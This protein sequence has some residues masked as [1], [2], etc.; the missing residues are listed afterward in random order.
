M[1]ENLPTL[2]LVVAVAV[3][4]VAVI[5]VVAT[6]VLAVARDKIKLCVIKNAV[7]NMMTA[8]FFIICCCVSYIHVGVCR[9]LFYELSTRSYFVAHEHRKDMI[10]FD[11]IFDG[12]LT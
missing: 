4:L 11:C 10:C 2:T 1:L 5:A 8:F 9:V 6:V 3:V 12:D 7:K